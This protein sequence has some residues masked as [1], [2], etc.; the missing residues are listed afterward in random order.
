[1]RMAP[2]WFGFESSLLFN[3]SRNRESN[4]LA[5]E[6]RKC[7]GTEIVEGIRRKEKIARL[8]SK[9]TESV[10]KRDKKIV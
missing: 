8:K 7:R 9:E 2:G 10:Q 4:F 5:N 1:M 6:M 3:F